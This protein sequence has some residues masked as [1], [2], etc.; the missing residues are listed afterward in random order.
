ML[1]KP[2]EQ[3]NESEI[4]QLTDLLK[5]EKFF[6]QADRK[7]LSYMEMREIASHLTFRRVGGLENIVEYGDEANHFYII[8]KGVVSIFI[9]NPEIAD[10]S[11]KRR[12]Y[13]KLLD[14]KK[15]QLDPRI[16][17]AKKLHLE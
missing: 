13:L 6:Q 4:D 8:I 10:W 5:K 9:P 16:E 7:N 11:V 17:K 2:I 3:R 12:D 15:N 14:W 1:E